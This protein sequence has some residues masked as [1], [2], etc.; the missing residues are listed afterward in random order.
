MEPRPNF[1]ETKIDLATPLS[2]KSAFRFPLQSAEARKEVLWG[3]MLLLI[4]LIG[5]LLNM[6]HRIEMVHRMQ[7]GKSAW[8]SWGKYNRLFRSGLIVWLGMV[9][10][11]APAMVL[12]AAGW[13]FGNAWVYAA[14][15]LAFLLASIAI[16]GYMTHYCRTYDYREI[17]NPLRAFH[18]IQEGGSAY[19][20]AW[21]IALAALSVSLLGLL[22]LG[23]GFLVTSVWFWQVAGYS[24]A[25]VFSKKFALTETGTR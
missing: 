17:F 4:P 15:L 18:R 10:Y 22:A 24:F 14:A 9:C 1:T 2:M 21:G 6:G 5:C 20:K 25:A 3:A 13:R 23:A 16:P 12:T 19:W 7:H 11:Y 8:P